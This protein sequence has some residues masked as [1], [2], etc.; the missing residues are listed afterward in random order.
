MAPAAD[1]L[2][3]DAA[4][5]GSLTRVK[6]AH[7]TR[8]QSGAM[9]AKALLA[10]LLSL[11]LPVA[12]SAAA[13]RPADAAAGE[14]R[15]RAL[16]ERNCS[17]CHAVG[18]AGASPFHPAPPFRELNQRYKIDDLAEALA[19][20]IITGHPAMPEF[21]FSPAEVND[22]IRYLKTIQTREAASLD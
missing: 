4:E 6:D 14:A 12:A 2:A 22:I 8:P 18:K 1:A 5:S 13:A 16:V 10:T 20:G 7:A 17:M 21:R 9:Y 3:G 19:E 11:A 15:G